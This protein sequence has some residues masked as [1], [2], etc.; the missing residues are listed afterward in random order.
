[1]EITSQANS[2]SAY[3]TNFYSKVFFFF[4]LAVLSSAAGCYIGLNYMAD[5]FLTNPATIYIMFALELGLVFTSR[6]WSTKVP[7]SYFLFFAFSVITGITLVPLIGSILASTGSLNLVIKAFLA[8]SLM[9]T[10]TAVFGITTH[11]NLQG[12][13]GF[14]VTSLIGLIVISVIGIF[15]P[16]GN[17]FE[18][19]FSG[20]GILIFSGYTMYDMQKLKSY[21]HDQY[22][23]AALRLY[24]DI[25]NL[26]LFVLRLM[27]SFGRE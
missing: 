22:I 3:N 13:S 17:T 25:F 5:F 12:L 6:M 24:L 7:L 4:G 18:M 14:L 20:F 26:F 16:W 8:T 1:M 15:I 2:Q 9:F 21:N 11:I 27:L 23:D 10:G 19:I